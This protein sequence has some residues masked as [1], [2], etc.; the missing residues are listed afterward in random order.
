MKIPL[1]IL[2][3]ALISLVSGSFARGEG[4]KSNKKSPHLPSKGERARNTQSYRECMLMGMNES[5]RRY[6]TNKTA[7]EIIVS[8]G[9]R[10]FVETGTSRMQNNFFGDGL[11]TVIF[12]CYA[13]AINGRLISVDIDPL[14]CAVSAH[15]I[16]AFKDNVKVIC[17]DSLPFLEN[18]RYLIDF[19]YL[20][21]YDYDQRLPHLSQQHHLKEIQAAYNNILI[22]NLL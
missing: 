6:S 11:F 7:F 19:L 20:D 5:F 2:A 9:L 17:S 3:S 15:Q 22:F 13:H 8:R 14:N 12:G 1:A 18:Y 4:P 16:S 10:H 21:S